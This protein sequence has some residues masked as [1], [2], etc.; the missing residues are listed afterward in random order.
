MDK[1]LS[2]PDKETLMKLDDDFF[3]RYERKKARLNQEMTRWEKLNEVMKVQTRKGPGIYKRTKTL[4][5][6]IAY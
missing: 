1:S 2:S 6:Q 4:T 5:C 3:A